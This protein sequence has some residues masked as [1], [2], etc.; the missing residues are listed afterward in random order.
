MK[1]KIQRRIQTTDPIGAQEAFDVAS[2]LSQSHGIV[3]TRGGMTQ[4]VDFL[5]KLET[6]ED[7]SKR[8]FESRSRTPTAAEDGIRDVDRAVIVNRRPD[9]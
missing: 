7:I 1:D 6:S 3:F 8:P 2:F 9:W 5:N 4:L